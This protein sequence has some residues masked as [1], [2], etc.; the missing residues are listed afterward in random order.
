MLDRLGLGQLRSAAKTAK[1][2]GNQTMFVTSSAGDFVLKGNPLYAGQFSEEQ[3][4]VDQLQARTGMPVPSPY[5]VDE[6]T[7]IVGWPYAVMPRLAGR[8]PA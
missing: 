7:D 2:V 8:H 5:L 4:C 3:F 6:G 1:G